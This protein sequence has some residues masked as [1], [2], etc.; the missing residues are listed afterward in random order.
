MLPAQDASLITPNLNQGTTIMTNNGWTTQTYRQCLEDCFTHALADSPVMLIGPPGVG[1]SALAAE[2]ADMMGLPLLDVRATYMD[3]PDLLGLYDTRDGRT[4]RLPPAWMP[5]DKPVLLLLDEINAA[6]MS[7]QVACYQIILNRQ[8]GDAKFAKGT[9][10]M[11]A[12]NRLE[13]KAAATRMSTA[14]NNRLGHI[15]MRADGVQWLSDFFW[16]HPLVDSKPESVV[17]IGQFLEWQKSSIHVF[18]PNSKENAFPSPRTWEMVMRICATD[19][20]LETQSRAILQTIGSGVGTMFN[21]FRHCLADIPSI[22]VILGNPT[23]APIPDNMSARIATCSSLAQD[24]SHSNVDAIF[25]Y[26][27]RMGK[28]EQFFTANLMPRFCQGIDR[29]HA[30]AKWQ[31]MNSEFNLA[32]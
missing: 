19:R 1:K 29:T 27:C 14:L 18:D 5:L 30:Y 32:Q 3:P 8:C 7:V 28:E 31:G 13:D 20:S 10:V 17:C 21:T 4:Y 6:P 2:L 25:K 12:G 15:E 11:G 23:T 16:K 9:Y 22:G 26:V 24:A